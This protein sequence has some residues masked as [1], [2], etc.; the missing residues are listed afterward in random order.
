MPG[1]L[2]HQGSCVLPHWHYKEFLREFKEKRHFEPRQCIWLK[3][4]VH[5]QSQLTCICPWSWRQEL[6]P[7]WGCSSPSQL[8]FML[9][10]SSISFLA[11][12]SE[13]YR[14]GS[15]TR[16]NF[17]APSKSVSSKSSLVVCRQGKKHQEKPILYS[18][19]IPET[20]KP[21][22]LWK[23]AVTLLLLNLQQRVF[24]SIPATSIP[25]PQKKHVLHRTCQITARVPQEVVSFLKKRHI[26]VTGI[27]IFIWCMKMH[28]PQYNTVYSLL[29]I[30]VQHWR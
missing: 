28:K 17:K 20:I 30:P 5:D 8:T 16:K 13:R 24:V 15:C 2:T 26:F 1:I 21:Q 7:G 19:W 3:I 9:Q 12:S 10:A 6:L 25:P 23:A 14:L 4:N 22:Q 29:T 27:L 18:Y 11:F